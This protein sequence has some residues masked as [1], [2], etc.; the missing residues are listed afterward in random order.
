MRNRERESRD[1]FI[2]LEP[3]KGWVEGAGGGAPNRLSL[4]G[5]SK[6]GRLSLCC[7]FLFSLIEISGFF[8]HNFE[9]VKGVLFIILASYQRVFPDVRQA[10]R[11]PLGIA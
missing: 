5:L 4:E 11:K 10:V 8:S 2:D 9:T 3:G 7:L 1:R 6:L